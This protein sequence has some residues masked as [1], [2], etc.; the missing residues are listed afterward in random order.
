MGMDR[1]REILRGKGRD[2]GSDERLVSG[3]RVDGHD[4]FGRG[5]H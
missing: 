4:Q 5:D 3:V 2:V 1:E